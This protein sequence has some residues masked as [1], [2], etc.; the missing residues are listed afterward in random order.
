LGSD[1]YGILFSIQVSPPQEPAPIPRFN[2]KKANWELFKKELLDI[3]TRDSIQVYIDAIPRPSSNRS[4]SLITGNNPDL[5]E[6]LNKIGEILS[7]SI[8]EAAKAS[9][10]TAAT[11]PKPK[12][13]WNSDLQNIR[14]II[15]QA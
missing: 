9:I 8:L 10:P 4:L 15:T 2:T 12:P 5:A 13:W 6:Q 14:K 7:T 3:F 1:H 11:G